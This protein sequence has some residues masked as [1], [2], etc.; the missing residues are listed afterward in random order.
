MPSL[1]LPLAWRPNVLLVTT[2]SQRADTVAAWQNATGAAPTAFSPHADALAATGVVFRNAHTI[3]PVCSPARASLL[4]GVSPFVHGK[5]ENGIAGQMSSAAFAEDNN[6]SAAPL[7]VS[8]PWTR[9]LEQRGYATACFGKTDFGGGSGGFQHLDKAKR[10]PGH[11]Q[12][13]EG[14]VVDRTIAW[15]DKRTTALVWHP[16]A[17]HASFLTPHVQTGRSYRHSPIAPH[18]ARAY[19][20]RPLP[21]PRID[22]GA[23]DELSSQDVWLALRNFTADVVGEAARRAYYVRA[24][25]ADE[26]LGRLVGWLRRKS[27]QTRTLVIYTSDHGYLLGDHGLATKHTFHDGALRVPLILSLPGVLPAG[28]VRDFAGLLDVTATIVAAS[29][30]F[31]TMEPLPPEYQGFDLVAPIAAGRPSPRKAIAAA[32]YDSFAVV[33]PGWKLA[34]FPEAGEGRLWDRAADPREQL[35]L[36]QRAADNTTLGALRDGLLRAL[37]RWRSQ[38]LPLRFLRANANE[39]ATAGAEQVKA[40]TLDLR[41]ASVER[42]LQ[43]DALA[44]TG[45][46]YSSE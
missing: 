31:N 33:T 10:A 24:A 30:G 43:D 3:A 44:A 45:E 38:Q 25:H 34:Y 22:L 20:G 46:E 4:L 21:Q 36:Y 14:V 15:L 17:V 23:G 35:D 26:Q 2:D 40:H 11:N 7:R 27:L 6:K 42:S 37:M 8:D 39:R 28:A 16:F 1:R 13:F 9:L 32:L 18:L 12:S 41:M 19:D 29:S 5:L